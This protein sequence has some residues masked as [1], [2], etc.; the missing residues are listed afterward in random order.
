MWQQVTEITSKC[1]FTIAWDPSLQQRM[2]RFFQIIGKL[3]IL[4]FQLYINF[5]NC[6]ILV[7]RAIAQ[8]LYAGV[9]E[10]STDL[11]TEN[12]IQMYLYS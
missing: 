12:T 1:L 10:L 4:T 6:S 2:K 3:S 7:L 8:Q 9:Q 5:M 11:Y